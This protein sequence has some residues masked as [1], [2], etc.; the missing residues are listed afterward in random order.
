MSEKNKFDGVSS[1][2]TYIGPVVDNND[3]EKIGRVRVKVMD[4]FDDL[5]DEEIPW[6]SPWKDL[7]GNQFNIPDKGKVVTVIFENGNKNNPEYISSDHYNE[8]LEN[9]LKQLSKSDYLSMKSLL[10]D[11]K[12]QI[13]VN[14]TEG[15]KIDHKFNNINIKEES[16]SLNLKDNHRKLNLGSENAAQ[17]AI[18]GD[19]FTNWLDELLAIFMSGA[20]LGNFGAKVVPAPKLIKHIQ[21]YKATKNTKILSKNVFIVDNDYVKKTDRIAD[22]TL[23]DKW[24]STIEKNTLTKTEEIKYKPVEGSSAT[25]F[26]QP[27]ENKI[28]SGT[29]PK[30]TTEPV[31]KEANPDVKILL[32][33]IKHL[34]KMK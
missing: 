18:L 12:T 33:I 10:Y 32:E 27:A 29:T 5:K 6:D 20:F 19:T 13:Y 17:R 1:S 4:V 34:Y 8:N 7:N 9:K 30:T 26:E 11:H 2:K 23:G 31:V 15:L 28:V 24:K 21:L 3:P 16:I 25:T 14:D 22:G